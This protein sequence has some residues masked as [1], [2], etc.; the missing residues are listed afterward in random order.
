MPNYKTHSIHSE[1]VLKDIDTYVDIDKDEL[2]KFSFG[3]DSIL[4]TDYK[5]F[6]YQHCNKTKEYFETLLRIIKEEKL[7]D[8]KQVIAFLYGQLNHYVLD[9]ITHPLIYYMT[10]NMPK[11]YKINPHTLMEMWLDDYV[12]INYKK[13]E[14]YNKVL[15]LNK[16]LKNVIN[17]LY[18]KLFHKK[19]M[20]KDYQFG[21]LSFQEFDKVIRKNKNFLLR[22]IDKYFKIGDIF[23]QKNID[24]IK[25]FLNLEHDVIYHPVTGEPS[26]YSFDDLWYKEIE[27]AKDTI[28]DANN[29]LYKYA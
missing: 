21:M 13:E 16:N 18:M 7:L 19:N 12:I 24:R 5:L 29:Y 6:E 10:E 23:Y 8:D 20:Y 28:E 1:E 15:I 25:P 11:H 2:N 27:T 3:P 22:I 26:K 4:L 9:L 14:N 17:H